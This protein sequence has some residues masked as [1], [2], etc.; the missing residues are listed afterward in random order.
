M[1]SV[2]CS[3]FCTQ[4]IQKFNE[5]TNDGHGMCFF[6]L[7]RSEN[8]TNFQASVIHEIIERDIY[9]SMHVRKNPNNYIFEWKQR[10]VQSRE[11]EHLLVVSDTL[12]N[13]KPIHDC[14]LK[15][16]SSGLRVCIIRRWEERSRILV[17][18]CEKWSESVLAV[19]EKVKSPTF[20]QLYYSFS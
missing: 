7:F 8:T 5:K 20:T 11:H 19:A 14:F 1:S 13:W 4:I 6:A 17:V 18:L 10:I 9:I 3:Q 12:C 2:W 15:K 16:A